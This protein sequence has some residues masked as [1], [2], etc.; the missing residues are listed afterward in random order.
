MTAI[1]FG[2]LKLDPDAFW[3]MTLHEFQAAVRGLSG[4][5]GASPALTRGELELLMQQYPDGATSQ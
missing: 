4:D 2:V 1:G 3:S 5:V